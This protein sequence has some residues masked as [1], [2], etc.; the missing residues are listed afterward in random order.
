MVALLIHRTLQDFK[1]V[2]EVNIMILF[3][4]GS[5]KLLRKW[6]ICYI[7]VYKL[8]LKVFT[9]S[10]MVQL[11]ADILDILK[12]QWYCSGKGI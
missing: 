11:L 8:N 12:P 4:E 1:V 7:K 3:I 6:L 2:D 9:Q 5:L 10:E